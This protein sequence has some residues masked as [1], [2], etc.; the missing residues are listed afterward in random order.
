[1]KGRN[2]FKKAL[3]LLLSLTL[4]AG[5]VTVPQPREVKAAE[6]A[7]IPNA[8]MNDID[9]SLTGTSYINNWKQESDVQG[10]M[11]VSNNFVT[12]KW[13]NLISGNCY[14]YVP[15]VCVGDV[16]L[17]SEPITLATDQ[18]YYKVGGKVKTASSSDTNIH[19][20]VRYEYQD[21]A[22]NI[23]SL[24]TVTIDTL[25]GGSDG[26]YT[27][28]SG[29]FRKDAEAEKTYLIFCMADKQEGIYDVNTP[30]EMYVDDTFIEAVG[31]PAVNTDFD[32]TD[33]LQEEYSSE[34]GYASTQE[35][36]TCTSTTDHVYGGTSS[37]EIK[38]DSYVKENY[39]ASGGRLTDLATEGILCTAEMS[40]TW[41][42][43]IKSQNS[44]AFIR[45]DID[46]YDSSDKLLGTLKGRETMLSRSNE[47]GEWTKVTT[48]AALPKGIDEGTYMVYRIAVTSGTAEVY[49]DNVFGKITETYYEKI[50]DWSE[51]DGTAEWQ[52]ASIVDGIG[53]VSAGVMSRKVDTLVPGATYE[54]IGKYSASTAGTVTIDFYNL[55]EEKTTHTEVLAERPN[56]STAKEK[57]CSFAVPEGTVYADISFG[58]EGTYT[59]SEYV[60]CES[61]GRTVEN[62]WNG[63]WIWY[64]ENILTDGQ[65]ETRYFKKTF[66]ISSLDTI[67]GAFLQIAADDILSSVKLNDTALTT[68][69]YDTTYGQAPYTDSGKR[70]VNV[71]DL[72]DSLQIGDN[73]LEIEILNQSSYGGLLFE[74]EIYMSDGSGAVFY[75]S[76]ETAL[77]STDGSTWVP[78]RKLGSPAYGLISDVTYWRR[79]VSN[80]S[81]ILAINP[82]FIDETLI[83]KAGETI[84]KTATTIEAMSVDEAEKYKE[85][86]FIGRLYNT[87]DGL[88][89]GIVPITM[90]VIKR[91][92]PKSEATFEIKI[93][94]YVPTGTYEIRAD[95][96]EIRLLWNGSNRL[97]SVN[98]EAPDTTTLTKA[99]IENGK[100]VVDESYVSPIL[101]LRPNM[102]GLYN[103][104][105]MS[106]FQD[107]GVELYATYNGYL[108][109]YDYAY[110][111]YAYKTDGNEATDPAD[112]LLWTE[113]D[114]EGNP[115]L[116]YKWFDY[117]IMRTLDLT[118]NEN[119]KVLVNICVDAPNWWAEKHQD[120]CVTYMDEGGKTHRLITREDEPA[121]SSYQVS[122][123]SEAYQ[124]D[125]TK[126]IKAIV[127]HMQ[128]ASYAERVMGVRFVA[129]RTHEWMQYGVGSGQLVDYS[130]ATLT[131]F[132]AW[133]TEKYGTDAALQAAWNDSKATLSGATIPNVAERNPETNTAL[134]DNSKYQKAI[135]YNTFLGEA[136][137]DYLVSLC[138]AA[139]DVNSDWLTGAYNGY[140]WN[141]TSSEGIG[142]AHTAS[143]IVLA[144]EY[145]DFIASPMNYGERVDGYATSHMVLSDSVAAAGK[146]Y[147][148]EMDNRTLHAQVESNSV[149]SLGKTDTVIDTVQ[150]LTR[151]MSLNFVRGTG[152]WF[153]DMNGGWFQDDSIEARI[154]T[155]KAEFDKHLETATNNEVAV[156]VAEDN[157]NHVVADIVGNDTNRTTSLFTSLY[158][159]QRRELSAMGAS[160]DVFSIGDV[161]KGKVTRDYKL[162]IV[163]SPFE[164]TDGEAAELKKS[165]AKNDQVVL[166]IY[167]PGISDGT[168]LAAENIERLVDMNVTFHNEAHALNATI[169]SQT[170]ISVDEG[171]K[172][173]NSN[174]KTGPWAEIIDGTRLATYTSGETA[175]AYVEKEGYTSVYSAVP[176]VPAELLRA[177]CKKAGVHLYSDDMS[178][179]VE[180]NSSYLAI[181][182]VNGG[183]KTISLTGEQAS[184]QVWDVL[185]KKYVDITDG[186]FT[187]AHTAGETR[188]Y[189][190][191]AER[192]EET[193]TGQMTWTDVTDNPDN[194]NR[195]LNGTFDKTD[196]S[197]NRGDWATGNPA[198]AG[199]E[200][201]QEIN[202]SANKMNVSSTS[203]FDNASVSTSVTALHAWN[204]NTSNVVSTQLA[205]EA[206]EDR[207][208]VLKFTKEA[209]GSQY[210]TYYGV[211][212]ETGKTYH[213]TFDA[214]S[215]DEVSL[216]FYYTANNSTISSSASAK[217]LG[218]EWT[219]YDITFTVETESITT[220]SAYI[221]LYE[222]NQKGAVYLDDLCIT[223]I[224]TGD[225]YYTE[226]YGTFGEGDNALMVES[227]TDFWYYGATL[228]E[229]KT[230]QYSMSVKVE[231]AGDDFEFYPYL[232]DYA[233]NKPINLVELR[234]TTD[235]DWKTI[236][237]QITAPEGAS[238]TGKAR[239][240][241]VR[242][243]TGKVY[244]DDL[245]VT[246]I[247][248]K[249]TVPEQDNL[250]PNGDNLSGWSGATEISCFAT[251]EGGMG[252]G[253]KGT[254]ISTAFKVGKK[255]QGGQEYI[256][257]FRAD[258][259]NA[260]DILVTVGNARLSPSTS[261]VEET[262]W[263]E[264]FCIFTPTA[265]GTNTITFQTDGNEISLDD[266]CLYP[267]YQLG[268]ANGDNVLDSRDLIRYK[269]GQQGVELA[270]YIFADFD[271]TG[272][273]IDFDHKVGVVVN[274][275][276]VDAYRKYVVLRRKVKNIAVNSDFS[277][278]LNFGT[279]WTKSSNTTAAPQIE[280][281]ALAMTRDANVT[282]APYYYYTNS[283]ALFEEGRTYTV[284]YMAK[285]TGTVTW[286]DALVRILEEDK[287]GVNGNYQKSAEWTEHTYTFTATKALTW[288][289]VAFQLTSGEGTLYIDNFRIQYEVGEDEEG[290]IYLP[291][292]FWAWLDAE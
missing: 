134:L 266:V 243:G 81:S 232:L 99:S 38:K 77:S 249:Y 27:E 85:H 70:Q 23:T 44:N 155:L 47:E 96:D 290:E 42:M 177:L 284:S 264:F 204:L 262:G 285:T 291:Y 10:E 197:Y 105:K 245:V 109:G 4:I 161:L 206:Y 222:T 195:F 237:C 281:G 144:S 75:P 89:Y 218:S 239:F 163:L 107:S 242:N 184:G 18:T 84:I 261:I 88:Y 173:G 176:D 250:V 91:A 19:L 116:N 117:E 172:Y 118:V 174:A 216:Q 175:A 215:D 201:V 63:E 45:M 287:Y 49:V 125:V 210:I 147:M 126:V 154:A 100:L 36:F 59:L 65:N 169:V 170:A 39:V 40:Y 202:E 265:A 289:H 141:F 11:G 112:Y 240:G 83:G 121:L 283:T 168:S 255:M 130:V 236:T 219:T 33:G 220:S 128:T 120:D 246:E 136:G 13:D 227:K 259:T 21:E 2:K 64:P 196:G 223:E 78:S 111:M 187:Y 279:N 211:T 76:D 115:Q 135:D 257:R 200:Y 280:D 228:E 268:D 25:Y 138:K 14:A 188:L 66:N 225:A 226:G 32:T 69:H 1:M 143:S 22:G 179:V 209:K 93:P 35:E 231:G 233:T 277:G 41:G 17:K 72:A 229:G 288:P 119:A 230:Y 24:K 98:V 110:K 37:L 28:I 92:Y 214:K 282:N 58:G 101:Y 16:R 46:V 90:N 142:S 86:S 199:S 207:G 286:S 278:N 113:N 258:V 150:Q 146:L 31:E 127:E 274:Q 272:E 271:G 15:K 52:G 263:K 106:A 73:T 87:T 260:E 254:E 145:V 26:A 7:S 238:N 292:S 71:Y 153:Y 276:D 171:I 43:Y 162:N 193:V 181:H 194:T 67:D 137:A 205:I 123:A 158:A 97:C 241:F 190:L 186:Q 247:G 60:L 114:A 12:A 198:L 20:Q 34:Y 189:R 56:A 54:M 140:S 182:S 157:Y 244:L 5:L 166:W 251:A 57:I 208:H 108:N 178:D 3:G 221:N 275:K 234:I 122:M 151:D 139:K 104:D 273:G 80:E 164:L 191:E 132:R 180:T 94:D 270:T 160:Y 217:T 82:G 252:V 55:A 149:T 185:N 183:E 29:Y 74:I 61:H 62:S 148:V 156:F 95:M 124:K 102:N 253:A 129:G 152:M 224:T 48:T 50:A 192:S 256:L 248:N 133:L 68:Q 103:Y 6:T 79:I 269:K 51:F 167:M 235:C 212:L 213:V 8:N 165:L 267:K 53:K 131:A 9:Y 159:E 203:L 30:A